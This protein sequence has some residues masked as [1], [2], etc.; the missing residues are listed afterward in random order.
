MRQV[1]GLDP[2]RDALA[3]LEVVSQLAEDAAVASHQHQAVTI[4]R[5]QMRQF[6]PYAAGCAGN[7][8]RLGSEERVAGTH[9]LVIADFEVALQ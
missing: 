4:A 6:Q 3:R 8:G 7:E 9:D 2:H 5:E 1:L